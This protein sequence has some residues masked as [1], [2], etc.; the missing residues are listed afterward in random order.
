MKK[1]E[2]DNPIWGGGGG[3]GEVMELGIKGR[4]KDGLKKTVRGP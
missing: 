1:R 2:W 3:S 4:G